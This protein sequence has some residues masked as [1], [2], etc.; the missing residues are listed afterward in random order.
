MLAYR[1]KYTSDC[2]NNIGNG[3]VTIKIVRKDL[4]YLIVWPR[5][6]FPIWPMAAILEIS[7]KRYPPDFWRYWIQRFHLCSNFF[8]VRGFWEL[9]LCDWLYGGLYITM[10][11]SNSLSSAI[12]VRTMDGRLKM[13]YE[14]MVHMCFRFQVYLIDKQWF[15][16]NRKWS[17]CASRI[18]PWACNEFIQHTTHVW[19]QFRIRF[20]KYDNQYHK[21]CGVVWLNE[22]KS[23]QH[24]C[25]SFNI[26]HKP[27]QELHANRPSAAAVKVIVPFLTLNTK[28]WQH[29]MQCSNMR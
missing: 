2:I 29:P 17:C 25:T 7:L 1:V 5:V 13:K 9:V 20:L 8:L 16:K 21:K 28:Y 19:K 27:K 6:N 10:H 26:S 23:N 12:I 18:T 15:D 4:L 3:F 14:V 22:N 24:Y 11:Y